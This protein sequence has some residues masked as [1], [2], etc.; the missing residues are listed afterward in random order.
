MYLRFPGNLHRLSGNALGT[1]KE[2]C[3]I[4][5]P[6]QP[7]EI[8]TYISHLLGA[9]MDK[10]INRLKVMTRSFNLTGLLLFYRNRC[11]TQGERE[12]N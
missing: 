10:Q 8:Q 7:E 3:R 9:V 2:E 11:R 4:M 5:C 1:Q 6:P 12:Y